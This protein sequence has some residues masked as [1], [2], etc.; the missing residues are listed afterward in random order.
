VKIIVT[1]G[2]GKFGQ[3][4]VRDLLSHKHEVAVFDRARTPQIEGSHYIQGDIENLGEVLGAIHGT[5]AIIHLAAIPTHGL[6]ANEVTFRNNAMGAFNVHEA[7]WR[8]GIKRVVSLSSEAALGWAPGAWER[9]HLPDYLPLD[10]D[11]PCRPQDC[12]GLSK[13]VSEAIAKS[14]T[15]KCGMETVLIRAPWIVTP[16]E[17][18]ALRTTN[19][20]TPTRFT[21]YHYIDVRDLAE[22][23]RL[24]VER[25]ITG[26]VVLMVGSGDS[27]L[28]EPLSSVLPRLMPSL[29]DMA[30]NLT[31][32]RPAVSIARAKE[33]LGW[34]PRH[35]WRDRTDN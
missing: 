24:A 1:G 18:Q 29:G 27:S 21:T 17:L 13:Q 22:A 15:A 33:V 16:E 32:S 9:E 4:M 30:E 5:D 12:Y 10:E 25:P 35:F 8:L 7:A 3:W 26:S 2:C 20:R 34:S 14:Y 11:H 19:G 31:G 28:A 6:T 23:C